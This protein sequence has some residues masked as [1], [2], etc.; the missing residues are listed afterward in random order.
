MREL[1]QTFDRSANTA[2]GHPQGQGPAQGGLESLP[3]PQIQLTGPCI[4]LLPRAAAMGQTTKWRCVPHS[5]GSPAYLVSLPGSRH[6]KDLQGSQPILHTNHSQPGMGCRG[7]RGMAPHTRGQ[8][9]SPQGQTPFTCHLEMT[10]PER[11]W[12][13]ETPSSVLSAL[14][15][16]TA[17]PQTYPLM[18]VPS[19]HGMSG[20]GGR[21]PSRLKQNEHPGFQRVA[22]A[23]SKR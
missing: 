8:P 7:Q 13:G 18:G 23:L 11:G 14:K 21:E 1:S 22:V 17:R 5:P 15:Q 16:M 9:M 20:G 3:R 19:L 2:K 6:P 4:A 10:T 12:G